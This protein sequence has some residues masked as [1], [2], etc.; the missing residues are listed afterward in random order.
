[1]SVR[2]TDRRAA[3]LAGAP[4]FGDSQKYGKSTDNSFT[5][6]ADTFLVQRGK[7]LGY[8]RWTRQV[9]RT[10]QGIGLIKAVILLKLQVEN[11]LAVI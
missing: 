3:T 11:Y 7:T 9:V 4:S 2:E 6:T 5:D 10:E 1:M 8:F